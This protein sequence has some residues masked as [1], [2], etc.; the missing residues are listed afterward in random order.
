MT[1]ANKITV[2]RIISIPIFIIVLLQGHIG[3]ARWIF[4][5]SIFSDALDG[6]IARFRGERTR[7][8]TFLDPLADKLLLVATFIAFTYLGWIP[9]WIFV[10]VLSRDLLIVLGW[11]IV[12]ILT[13]NSNIQPRVLGKITTALQMGAALGKLI[14][15]PADLMQWLLMV[16]I[17]STVLSLVDYIW[18]GNKRLGSAT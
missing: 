3:A 18:A 2:L 17:V 12:Y 15:L 1:L 5:L 8:G 10:A 6:A 4:F 16:M 7:L 9:V 13:G 11:A 14:H